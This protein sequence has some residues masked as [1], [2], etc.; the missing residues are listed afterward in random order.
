MSA[1][2]K[3]I[4]FIFNYVIQIVFLTLILVFARK[5]FFSKTLFKILIIGVNIL[6]ESIIILLNRKKNA[7]F[8][9]YLV[10]TIITIDAII[11]GCEIIDYYG[12]MKYL[13]SVIYIRDLI[14]ATGGKGVI[15]FILIKILEVVCLP[16]PSVVIIVVGTLIYGPLLCFI[17]CTIGVVVGS[18]IAFLIGKTLGIKFFSWI[19]GEKNIT[20]YTNLLNKNA[21]F[22]LA[23]AF[24]FPFFPDDI[25][26]IVAGLTN[27]K[28]SKFIL[29]TICTKPVG[30]FIMSFLGTGFRIP[31]KGWGILIWITLF[32]VIIVALFIWLK[33]RRKIE[34]LFAKK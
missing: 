8:V 13:T 19:F 6:L 32:L 2:K 17:F 27:M 21:T 3:V 22:F 11:L 10:V 18:S 24:L 16:I 5:G 20:K 30:I 14:V 29:I 25:L 34:T 33:N 1:I 4:N 12:I 28:L 7:K 26:C 15:V 31:F 23:I 9:K